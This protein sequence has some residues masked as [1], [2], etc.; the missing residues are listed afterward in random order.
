MDG[1]LCVDYDPRYRPWYVTATS[2]GKNVIL[3]I[4]ISGS[5]DGTRINI[6]K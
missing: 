3:F 1:D 5:M 6:A 4:D 2:G